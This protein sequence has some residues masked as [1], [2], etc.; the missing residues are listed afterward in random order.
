MWSLNVLVLFMR[1]WR[2]FQAVSVLH[3]AWSESWS[4]L[5]VSYIRKVCSY[6]LWLQSVLFHVVLY[7]Q[8]ETAAW[9]VAMCWFG[10]FSSEEISVSLVGPKKAARCL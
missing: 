5:I 4:E 3:S 2:A 10:I 6:K 1:A 9:C 7:E 8:L